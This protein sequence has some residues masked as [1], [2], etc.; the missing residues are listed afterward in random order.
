MSKMTMN[1]LPGWLV[2][3]VKYDLRLVQFRAPF[4]GV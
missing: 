1:R 2:G 3:K 4:L